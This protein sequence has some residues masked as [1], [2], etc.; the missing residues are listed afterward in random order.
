MSNTVFNYLDFKPT[1][2]EGVFISPG[3]FIIGRVTLK[4][5]SNI[6]FNCVLR[7]DVN[8]IVVG[9]NTNVQDLSML[10]VTAKD[11]L[12]IGNN[13]S[14]GHSVTLHGCTI[15]D[16]CLIGMQALIL[17]GAEI[18]HSS[19][20]AAGSLVSPGKKFPP[21]SLIKG[22]PAVVERPLRPEEINTITNHYKSYTGYK[23]IYLTDKNFNES[24][25]KYLQPYS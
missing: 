6:W 5:H 15:N 1:I 17:D 13:I 11:A 21:F 20:V 9:E 4:K 19:L 16:S 7:G 14:I 2:E 10:H 24:L 3:A 12:I 25:K 22:R 18:G 23:D 8:E